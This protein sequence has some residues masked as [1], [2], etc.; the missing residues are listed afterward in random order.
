MRLSVAR[1]S[2]VLPSLTLSRL[3]EE[4]P[5]L[6]DQACLVLQLGVEKSNLAAQ[7]FIGLQH[8]PVPAQV[9]NISWFH[10]WCQAQGHET[11]KKMLFVGRKLWVLDTFLTLIHP[12]RDLFIFLLRRTCSVQMRF[13]TV[14]CWCSSSEALQFPEHIHF[15]IIPPYYHCLSSLLNCS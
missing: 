3:V 8:A 6:P 10:F 9:H 5:E 7:G 1:C 12:D 2:A 15:I 13:S 14:I 4:R 11:D